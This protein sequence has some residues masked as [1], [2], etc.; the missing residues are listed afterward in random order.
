MSWYLGLTVAWRNK[1]D[2]LQRKMARFVLGIGPRAHVG[3]GTLR[4]LGWL[5]VWDRVRYFSLLHVYRVR[6]GTGPQYLRGN[7]KL[8]SDV[9]GYKTRGSSTGFHISG[10][11]VVGSFEYCG[12]TEWNSLPDRLKTLG[13]IDAFK[14]NL[15]LYFLEG[16]R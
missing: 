2:V 12:K 5:T 7:F 8:V 6:K 11:D 15:K 9:H 14:R 4:E 10:E 16:Y 3:L 13:S 1:L